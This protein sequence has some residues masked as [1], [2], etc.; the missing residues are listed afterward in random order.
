MKWIIRLL[1]ILMSVGWVAPAWF[2]ITSLLQWCDQEM[3]ETHHLNS[4]DLLGLFRYSIFIT[5]IWIVIITCGWIMTF[6]RAKDQ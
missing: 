3:N 6:F 1:L 2:G 5:L 4:A